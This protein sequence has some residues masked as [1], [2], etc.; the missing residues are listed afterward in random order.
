MPGTVAKTT[1]QIIEAHQSQLDNIV[2]ITGEDNTVVQGG[3]NSIVKNVV[4]NFFMGKQTITEIDQEELLKSTQQIAD[5]ILDP[6]GKLGNLNINVEKILSRPTPGTTLSINELISLFGPR[7]KSLLILGDPGSGKTFALRSL[8]RVMTLYAKQCHD[9]HNYGYRIP[10][11]LTLSNWSL[12]ISQAN[13]K[14][15]FEKYLLDA[16]SKEYSLSANKAEALIQQAN[17][18]LLLDGLD[19]VTLDARPDCVGAMNVFHKEYASI[20]IVVVCRQKDYYSLPVSL[21]FQQVICLCP[22]SR[23]ALNAYFEQNPKHA[24]LKTL[25]YEYPVLYEF[26]DSPLAFSMIIK[27]Y[28]ET[29]SEEWEHWIK[30]IDFL[31]H[32]FEKY[33]RYNLEKAQ[34]FPHVLAN[35]KH[36]TWIA[37]QMGR[38]GQ[39]QIYIE[40]IGANWLEGRWQKGLFEILYQALVGLLVGGIF[41]IPY[42]NLVTGFEVALISIAS[43]FIAVTVRNRTIK[44][45][46]VAAFS[47]VF[48]SYFLP[49]QTK[50]LT[51]EHYIQIGV[52][53]VSISMMALSTDISI[54][55]KLEWSWQHFRQKFPLFVGT[56]LIVSIFLVLLNPPGQIF[57]IMFNGIVSLAL[58]ILALAGLKEVYRPVTYPNEGSDRLKRTAFRMLIFTPMFSII[59]GLGAG[60][61]RA[62]LPNAEPDTIGGLAIFTGLV[63]LLSAAPL[64]IAIGGGAYLRQML[65]Y[66]FLLFSGHLPWGS[67]R[68][69]DDFVKLGFLQQA[70][71]RYTFIHPL[72]QNY[73]A[74][75]YT[76]K[77]KSR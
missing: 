5:E 64:S 31:T 57:D 40:Q 50:S 69:F 67:R 4:S 53:C 72:F 46:L 55:H 66:C 76:S 36:L 39:T 48:L 52:F 77:E 73:M 62:L 70:G 65:G 17:L 59:L 47:A 10:V 68:F 56:F 23:D 13:A 60:C 11:V 21:E 1:S 38:L 37:R 6:A 43:G 3:G 44:V 16:L 58:P 20:P 26:T 30:S 49:F 12:F 41:A 61:L 45:G 18:I 2:Q 15:S 71:G 63:G 8:A 51:T 54:T 22:L 24:S 14:V 33:D 7:Q 25:F 19:E 27:I 35:Y 75:N 9:N 32:L 28:S 29:S 34:A 74:Q 42:G